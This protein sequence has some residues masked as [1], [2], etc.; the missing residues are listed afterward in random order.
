[1]YIDTVIGQEIAV[2][3]LKSIIKKPENCPSLILIVGPY[4][5]GRKYIANALIRNYF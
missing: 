5:T 2:T 4:G 1:M 3:C